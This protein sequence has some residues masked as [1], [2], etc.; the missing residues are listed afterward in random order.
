MRRSIDEKAIHP[1]RNSPTAHRGEGEDIGVGALVGTSALSRCTSHPL[2]P[3]ERTLQPNPMRGQED[4][5]KPQQ[6]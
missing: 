6:I 4:Q 2:H 3:M 5:L 1:T